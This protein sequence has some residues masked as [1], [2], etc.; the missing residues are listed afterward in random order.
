MSPL[1]RMV[2]LLIAF[3]GVACA[4]YGSM[5]APTTAVVPGGDWA[6]SGARNGGSGL[7]IA[8]GPNASHPKITHVVIIFQENRST[9][10]LF[11]GLPGAHTVKSGFDSKGAVVSL[12]PVSLKAKYD[13]DHSYNGFNTEFDSGKMDGFNLELSSCNTRGRV[14]GPKARRAYGYVPQKEVQPYFDMAQQYVFGDD[15]FQT[16][17]G[18][19]F[20]AHQYILSGTSTISTGSSYRASGWASAPDQTVDG[21]CDS[22]DGSLAMTIDAAGQQRR[23]VFP[24]F[25][26]PSLTD[27]IDAKSL[28]WRYYISSKH[29][30]VWNGPDAIKH[31]RQSSEYATNVITPPSQLLTD[32]AQNRLASV[33]WV[34]PTAR[35]SDHANITDGS[36]PSWVASI[37]NAIGQGPYWNQTA[38]F[39]TWDDWGGWYD[40]VAP[41]QY[42]AYELGFRVP[43]L[44]IAPYAKQ[45]FV[46]H[47]QH[48]F[49]SILKFVEQTFNLGS[50][51]TTDMRADNLADCFD[52]SKPPRKFKRIAAPLDGNYFLHQAPSEEIVD[53]Y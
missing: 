29:A 53:D 22:P 45:G 37:V 21:G 31:I 17:E 20:P 7:S 47:K 14:C 46:S 24:C 35:A 52:F 39:V 8:N 19:S 6:V 11:N 40:D 15:M 9:D 27:L 18:P 30:N 43:L 49:G 1:K 10:N 32:I 42:N 5:R 13:L 23:Q 34:T 28:T 48:E 3:T 50:L 38:I 44:V 41:Q 51:G 26:R 33:V 4:Q 16:N 2:T 36:G 12:R 25:E